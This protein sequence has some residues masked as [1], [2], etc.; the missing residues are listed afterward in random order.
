MGSSMSW[1]DAVTLGVL[2]ELRQVEFISS[3]FRDKK[4]EANGR[5]HRTKRRD[6]KNVG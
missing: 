4:G 1:P 2:G 3:S 6:K 5:R